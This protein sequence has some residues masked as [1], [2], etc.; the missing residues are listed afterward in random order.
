[1]AGWACGAW[2]QQALP[3]LSAAD[4][5]AMVEALRA[6]GDPSPNSRDEAALRSAVLR[7]AQRELGQRIR[8]AAVDRM[9]SIQPPRRDVAAELAAAEA[10]GRL[11]QWLKALSPPYGQYQRLQAALLRYRGIVEAGGWPT[12]A[13]K[14]KLKEDVQDP[15]V[16]V[17]R[18]RLAAEGYGQATAAQP[19]RF[20]AALKA[21]LILFQQHHG[22]PEDGVVGPATRAAL[23]V[24]AEARL[25]QIE[26]NLE[27]WRWLPRA[28][29]GDRMMIDIGGARAA[30]FQAG[31]PI[32][33]MKVVVGDPRHHTPMFASKLDAVVFNP[34][35]KVPT[36]IAV[37]EILPKARR[38][39]GYLGRNHFVYVEGR[40]TQRPG[41]KNS[42]G[43][44]K[45][46]LPSPFGVYLHDTPVKGAFGRPVRALSHGCMRLEKPR[47]LAVILLGRQGW[48]EEMVDQAVAA[49]ATR[50][51]DL[52]TQVPLYVSYW[53][54]VADASGEL[55]FRPDVY[56]WDRKLVDA[57]GPPLEKRAALPR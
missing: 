40:L 11:S 1:M 17:L 15:Q 25:Q 19:D 53:T 27:R 47:D 42:L 23:N 21:A 31:Q 3:A 57:L 34:P 39:P 24:P 4:R 32:L 6:A 49:G 20:D 56:G 46:D 43:Q 12:L 29:P 44:I 7:L 8:P 35:W 55:D 33:R 9:W 10:N 45:F 41:P 51:V 28:P 13:G 36:S 50:R 38:D 22:L 18:Q 5:Q 48:T 2:A 14:A 26:A 30:L 54:V 52:K 37:K 16:E